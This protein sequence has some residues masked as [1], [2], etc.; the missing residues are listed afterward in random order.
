MQG[1]ETRRFTPATPLRQ[2]RTPPSHLRS[3]WYRCERLLRLQFVRQQGQRKPS[4]T[5]VLC[6]MECDAPTLSLY[7]QEQEPRSKSDSTECQLA[8][9]AENMGFVVP[10]ATSARGA[11]LRTGSEKRPVRVDDEVGPPMRTSAGVPRQRQEPR[12]TL[13]CCPTYGVRSHPTTPSLYAAK[14]KV[15]TTVQDFLLG[16]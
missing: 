10:P 12:Q 9:S 13:L 1:V 14:A 11:P 3:S 8:N 2:H 16:R 5:P 4:D 6:A 15:Q 7:T